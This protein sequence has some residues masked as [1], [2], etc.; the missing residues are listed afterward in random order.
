MATGDKKKLLEEIDAM[1]EK[2]EER[3]KLLQLM[4]LLSAGR[5][6][7]VPPSKQSPP[8]EPMTPE[9]MLANKYPFTGV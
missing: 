1:Y 4:D 3:P 8:E 6:A 7:T 9:E 2:A 5:G